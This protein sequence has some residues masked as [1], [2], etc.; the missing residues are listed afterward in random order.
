MI[1]FPTDQFD[2]VDQYGT[3]GGAQTTERSQHQVAT[4]SNHAPLGDHL[5]E[6][7][8]PSSLPIGRTPLLEPFFDPALFMLAQQLDDLEGVRKA[9]ANR[10]RVLTATEPDEDG[11]MRGFGLSADE[12]AVVALNALQEGSAALEHETIL[13]LQRALRKHPLGGFQKLHKGVGEKQLARLLGAI[14]D[15]YVRGDGTT[16]TVSQLW[17]YGGLHTLSSQEGGNVAAKRMKGVK[18]NWSTDIKTRA[19]LISVSCI[20]QKGDYR[21]AYEQ[22]RAR[23]AET[24]PDWSPGHSHNDGLRFV[25]KRLLRDLWRYSRDLHGNGPEVEL[26][27]GVQE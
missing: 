1:P 12:P 22:R 23:T 16:R 26:G 20:K 24:H 15:P 5:P 13:S 25:S 18:A 27:A 7:A 4:Q 19:Y 6:E 14:G 9:Q 11:V 21:E 10:I 2:N 17:A 3:V 8:T